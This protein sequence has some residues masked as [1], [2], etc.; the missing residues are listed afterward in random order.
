MFSPLRSLC[1]LPKYSLMVIPFGISSRRG[2]LFFSYSISRSMNLLI[3]ISRLGK[4]L[5]E[6]WVYPY[7]FL[8]YTYSLSYFEAKVKG[9]FNLFSFFL[10]GEVGLEP[11]ISTVSEWCSNRLNYSPVECPTGFEPAKNG[12]AIRCLTIQPQTHW[13]SQWDLNPCC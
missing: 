9:L 5:I 1:S 11:T 6:N 8:N 2:I 12:F 7:L 4:S 10:V 3:I 13:R